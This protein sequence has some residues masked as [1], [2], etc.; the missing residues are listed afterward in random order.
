MKQVLW[1]LRDRSAATAI[2]YMLLLSG[3][4]LAIVGILSAFGLQLNDIF[5]VL[6]AA[7]T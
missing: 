6:A 5:L 3:L 4:A 1:L 2:E 7:N